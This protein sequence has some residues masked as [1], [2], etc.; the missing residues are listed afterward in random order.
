MESVAHDRIRVR[1][2]ALIIRP[3][4]VLYWYAAFST[5]QLL[6]LQCTSIV[7]AGDQLKFQETLRCAK[8]NTTA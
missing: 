8:L 5:C 2:L 6:P 4:E 7:L 3:S 1:L